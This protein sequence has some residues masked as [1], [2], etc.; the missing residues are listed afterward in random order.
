MK[1]S[2][3]PTEKRQ[4]CPATSASYT[5]QWSKSDDSINN[6]QSNEKTSREFNRNR[7]G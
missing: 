7:A 6:N 4:S 3:S 2:P 5:I 1:L